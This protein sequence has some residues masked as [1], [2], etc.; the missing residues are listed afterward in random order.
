MGNLAEMATSAPHIINNENMSFRVG[1]KV[2]DYFK[3]GKIMTRTQQ[4]KCRATDRQGGGGPDRIA[5]LEVGEKGRGTAMADPPCPR[6]RGADEEQTRNGAAKANANS[7]VANVHVTIRTLD[8][9]GS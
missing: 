4:G 2:L 5:A 9:G 1:T 7:G 8:G 3:S 6:D